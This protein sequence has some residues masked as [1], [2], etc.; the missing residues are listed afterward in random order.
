MLG[1]SIKKVIKA[2]VLASSWILLIAG[3][4]HLI[5]FDTLFPEVQIAFLCLFAFISLL[6]GGAM[7]NILNQE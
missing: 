7:Y 4:N 1:K 3:L 2:T 6:L 5:D